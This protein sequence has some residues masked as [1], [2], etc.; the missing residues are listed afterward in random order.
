MLKARYS[1]H[2]QNTDGGP[3]LDDLTVSARRMESCS[4]SL[5]SQH[6][7]DTAPS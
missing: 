7:I 6:R 1:R 2:V 4:L 3:I 5:F